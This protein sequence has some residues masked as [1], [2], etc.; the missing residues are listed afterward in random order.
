MNMFLTT[1]LLAAENGDG[2]DRSGLEMILPPVA[3][4]FW[5]AIAFGIVLVVVGK[6]AFPKMNTALEERAA[7]IQG[8]ISEAD[9]R[10]EQ[11]EQRRKEYED[12][13]S[14][15]KSEASSIVDDARQEAEQRRQE[16]IERAEEEAQQIKDRAESEA[17]AERDRTIQSLRGEIQR[18]SVRLAEKIVQRE[19]DDEA[20]AALIDDYIDSLQSSNGNGN[21]N[22]GASQDEPVGSS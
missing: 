16:I 14:E 5:G 7:A 13:I 9:E 3:E 17:A 21:G 19:I 15:A 1:L 8:R 10:F 18:L 6:L 22:G 12:A 4:L 2:Q 20:H 11:A